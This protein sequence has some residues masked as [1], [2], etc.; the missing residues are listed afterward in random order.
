MKHGRRSR[1]Y[2]AARRLLRAR[3][4][5]ARTLLKLHRALK[6]DHETEALL[7]ALVASRQSDLPL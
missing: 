6:M 1:A 3:L 2:L 5:E 4:R 7:V